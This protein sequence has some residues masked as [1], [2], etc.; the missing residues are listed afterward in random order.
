MCVYIY[1]TLFKGVVHEGCC[2]FHISL[3]SDS[4]PDSAL[5]AAQAGLLL[6]NAWILS[7]HAMSM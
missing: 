4:C 2:R 3:G 5:R 6:R 1:I 7:C